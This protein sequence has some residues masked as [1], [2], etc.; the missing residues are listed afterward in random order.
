[1]F[2]HILF[3]TDGTE[4]SNRVEAH[5]VSLAQ[6]FSSQITILHAY[7]L[8]EAMPVYEASYAYLDELEDYLAGQSKQIAH[9]TE[10]R[11]KLLNL[12]V[13]SLVLRGDPAQSVLNTATEQGCDLIVMGSHQRGPVRR[14]LLGSVS[15][16]V[17]HHS[18][19]PVVIVPAA[20]PT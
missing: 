13:Q 19:C 20:E 14:F 5:V 4:A 18:A 1:M 15:N 10:A 6:A 17:I 11:L 12:Q 2:Q 8:L 3:P 7:E 16:Y 9:Q